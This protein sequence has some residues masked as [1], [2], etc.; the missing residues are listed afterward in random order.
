M[1]KKTK[2]FVCRGFVVWAALNGM[3]SLAVAQNLR[4]ASLHPLITDL[5][6]QVGGARVSVE[7]VLTVSD[8]PHS[9]QPTAKDL[10]RLLSAQLILI[11][12]KGIETYLPRLRDNLH[13]GQKIVEVGKKVPS[14]KV[15]ADD[16]FICCPAHSR[17]SIDPHWWHSPSNM[18][19]AVRIL[20]REF[21]AADPAGKKIY[22]A[23]ARAAG[24]RLD[25][26]KKWARKE[27]AVIPRGSRTLATSH[28]A[29][30]YFCKEFGFRAAPVRGLNHEQETSMKYLAD[31]I[32]I[33]R[34]FK[35]KAVFPEASANPKVL[36]EMVR[37]TGAKL[38]GELV[39]DGTG[40]RSVTTYDAMIRHNV[41]TIVSALK[42]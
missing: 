24:K 8:N 30:G 35:V 27:L 17:G 2:K 18:K 19:R 37:T 16:L 1:S 42:P 41:K 34:K 14:I 10:K 3:A 13:S 15:V 33:L 28:A 40:N 29:F 5:A 23:N 6:V 38:G 7:P 4:V 31:T 22:A 20:E 26:L 39:A 9:F 36:R 25:A 21:S 11:S 32:K 12:G